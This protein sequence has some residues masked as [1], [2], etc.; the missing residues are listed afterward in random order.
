MMFVLG[1]SLLLIPVQTSAEEDPDFNGELRLRTDRVGQDGKERKHLEKQKE[2]ETE[3]ERIAPDLFGEKTRTAIEQ[4]KRERDEQL[5][6][7]KQSLF[8]GT[9]MAVKNPEEDLFTAEYAPSA[10][11]AGKKE[12]K[13]KTET[14]TGSGGFLAGGTLLFG[15][16][17]Y[18]IMRR[19]LG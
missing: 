6:K 15:T 8:S 17:V 10:I 13:E 9:E 18:M 7:A 12:A 1:L 3:M 2:K 4:K 16:L 14:G 11:T 5:E 19:T